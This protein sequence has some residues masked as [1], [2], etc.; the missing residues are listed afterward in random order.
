MKTNKGPEIVARM[1]ALAAR[2]TLVVFTVFALGGCSPASKTYNSETTPGID[3]KAYKTYAWLPTKDTAYSK[4]VNKRKFERALAKEVINQ[5]TK[6]GMT[7]D[8]LHPDC[9]FTYSLIMSRKYEI[10]QEKEVEY[11]P[12]VYAPDY[13][14]Q[15]YVYYF[16]ADNRPVVYNGKMNITTFRE[17][18]LVIDMVD[19]KDKKVVWRASAQAKR[20]EAYLPSL[21]ETLKIIV[22]EMFGKFPKK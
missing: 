17:G 10:D 3:F 18:S 7:L 13:G 2:M 15:G 9:L 12:Q 16:S 22:P 4:I 5:L 20:D 6:R 8:T 11:S 21:Q 19:T 1:A 14:T